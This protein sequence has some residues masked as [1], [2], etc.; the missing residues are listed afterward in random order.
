MQRGRAHVQEGGDAHRRE[1][2]PRR[3]HA[4][5]VHAARTRHSGGAADHRADAAGAAQPL[6]RPRRGVRQAPAHGE[7]RVPP[8]GGARRPPDRHRDR[9]AL[10][11]GRADAELG[12]LDGERAVP[13]GRRRA[14]L[15]QPVRDVALGGRAAAPLVPPEAAQVRRRVPLERARQGRVHDHVPV[16]A[17]ARRADVVE[18]VARVLRTCARPPR[19][20][21]PAR[22]A[23][24]PEER[25]APCRGV[26]PPDAGGT[27][28]GRPELR[29]KGR[30]REVSE[31]AVC[32]NGGQV[33]AP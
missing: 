5:R 7:P 14:G 16:L 1:L 12:G 2:R 10:S 19:Q 33:A 28:Q 9:R 11:E 18:R 23:H 32:R 30:R 22:D 20:E 21:E 27:P 24:G 8:V 17:V 25:P 29:H 26:L 31:G 4:A 6:R 3:G 13:P 15:R